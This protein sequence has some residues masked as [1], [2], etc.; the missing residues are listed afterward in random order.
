[1]EYYTLIVVSDER[2]PVRRIQV[3]KLRIRRAA[4]AVALVVMIGLAGLWDYWRVRSENSDLPRLRVEASEQADRI[5]AFEQTLA[6]LDGEL[7]RVRELERKVRIIA[8][9]PGATASGGVEVTDALP[10]ALDA[11]GSQL[12]VGV[13]M[14]LDGQGGPESGEDPLSQ[15]ELSLTSPET[16]QGSDA[17]RRLKGQVGD[18]RGGAEG[19][20]QA[21]EELISS[22]Q[23]KSNR[24][25]SMPSVWPTRGWLTSR[26]GPRI[27][28]F[29]GRTQLHGGIDIATREGTP[30]IAPARGHVTFVGRKGPLG[31]SVTI[32]HGHGVRTVYGHASE[33]H[34]KS[35][36]T[37]ERGQLIA[38]VGSTGRSTGPHLHY[39]IQIHG[40]AQNPLD[41][42]FD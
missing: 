22:L 3:P 27:S 32:D 28:P 5:R 8:N 4:G 34:V 24:L 6:G 38:D 31:K 19:R 2:S 23:D 29:T 36:E 18:L 25:A 14:Q 39:A 26:F 10:G 42:I 1:M 7:E 16:L 21:L 13:P 15:S 11:S 35:G 41:Y 40:K 9:L 37:V 17:L 12:P 20:S 30:V 33:I